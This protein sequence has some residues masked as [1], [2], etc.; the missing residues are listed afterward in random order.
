MKPSTNK[1][2]SEKLS[3]ALRDNLK[4]RKKKDMKKDSKTNDIKNIKAP[5]IALCLFLLSS[6]SSNIEKIGYAVKSH[7]L[8]KIKIN[9]STEKMVVATLGEPTTKSYFKPVTYFYMER[10]YKKLGFL[11]PKLIDQNITS[12][13]FNDK[14][15]V[16]KIKIYYTKDAK[17]L[18]YD[19]EKIEFDGNSISGFKQVLG[20]IG[21]YSSKAQ[22]ASK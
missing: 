15:V 6:C 12:I 4:R 8:E 7:D 17:I 2:N 3:Q 10:E 11:N 9:E 20:N 19:S 18:N 5:V 1:S 21:K 16:N 13:Q 22:K 14:A